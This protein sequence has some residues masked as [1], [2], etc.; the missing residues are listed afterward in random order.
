MK[1]LI[2]ALALLLG[3]GDSSGPDASAAD[4]SPTA[5]AATVRDAAGD[6]CEGECRTDAALDGGGDARPGD[7]GETA[8]A[9]LTA[10]LTTASGDDGNA[11][12]NASDGDVETRWSASEV[13]AWI[14]L[15]L[16]TNLPTSGVSI[17]WYRGDERR[18]SFEVAVSEDGD[19][20]RRV[21]GGA[22]SGMTSDAEEYG[23]GVTEAARFVRVTVYG[24]DVN[25]WASILELR[26]LGSGCGAWIED[27]FLLIGQS[28]MAG[29]APIESVDEPA[30]AGVYLL[31]DAGR[32]TP[33][34]NVP[35]GLNRYS[36]VGVAAAAGL[37]PG[38]TFGRDLAEATGRR[39]GLVVNARGGTAIAQWRPVDHEGDYALFDEAV[40]RARLALDNNPGAQ[41]RGIL[42]HQGEGDNRGGVEDYYVNDIDEIVTALRTTLDAPTAVFV[43]GEVGT[44]MGR[45]ARVNPEI[46]RI[47]EVV[48]L[49]GW[50]SSE[51]LTTHETDRDPWGPHFNSEG[52]RILGARYAEEVLRLA[53]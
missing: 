9:A 20:Y 43:A 3:C 33:A 31:D 21:F 50:V 44:W 7:G 8:C 45:G 5:D 18:A 29:R 32:W 11:A 16:P 34:S 36:T 49:S 14:E 41:L 35:N 28:N 1:K 42:W 13:G 39:I 23:F 26:A 30:P 12:A 6:G 47:P 10:V 38:T 51:G 46:R 22:S 40:A 15:E 25:D 2:Y 19:T 53:Y 27:I 17:A 37:G 52:Q 24:N 48:D 4:A